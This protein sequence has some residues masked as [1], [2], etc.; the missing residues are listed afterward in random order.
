M[1]LNFGSTKQKGGGT[2]SLVVPG[3]DAT[4]Q[5]LRKLNLEVAQENLSSLRK[6]REESDAYASSPEAALAREIETKGLQNIQSR[7]TGQAPVLS[8]EEQARLDTIYGRA[9]SEGDLQLQRFGRDLASSRGMT[10]A[11]SPIGGEVLDQRRRFGEG[12]AAQKAAA[13]L[14][15]GQAQSIFDQ[16]SAAFAKQLQDRAFQ[17]RLAIAGA[18]PASF[19]LQQNLFGERLSQGQ[20]TTRSFGNANATG[21]GVDLAKLLQAAGSSYTAF[22][23]GGGGGGRGFTGV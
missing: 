23:G 16:A 9:S 14:D 6:A 2:T 21:Y 3:P 10:T 22:G 13:S 17:N 18:T 8:P 20:G 7:L 15:L 4:E 5:E 11:D 1:S 12:L 19:G